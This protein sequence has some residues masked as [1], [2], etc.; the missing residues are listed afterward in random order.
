MS[1]NS[2]K[3]DSLVGLDCSGVDLEANK[4]FAKYNKVNFVK[5]VSKTGF[6]ELSYANFSPLQ[7]KCADRM[8]HW[9]VVKVIMCKQHNYGR[10]DDS[11]LN[12]MWLLKN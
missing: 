11:D 1:L 7:L 10:I 6:G 2:E 3:W 5:S 8:L 9:F 12:I 4:T